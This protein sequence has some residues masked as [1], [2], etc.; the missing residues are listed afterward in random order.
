MP[1]VEPEV[2]VLDGEHNI[3][4]S[5]RVSQEVISACY[6]ELVRQ[7][8]LLEGTLLKPN[9]VLAGRKCAE[10]PDAATVARYTLRVL[11]NTV[12]PAVPGIVFLSGGMS[13]EEATVNLNSLNRVQGAKPWALSFSFGRA[14]QASALKAWKGEDA[15]IAAMQATLL[16][17]AQV[18][19][20]THMRAQLHAD[21]A[22]ADA[23]MH[24]CGG[25]PVMT[26]KATV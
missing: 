9:M 10:Q 25:G 16:V 14:L 23:Q 8:V 11:Q 21:A 26:L 13:E 12:P 15:N 2:L 4:Q 7:N 22:R 6:R 18:R 24:V 1:I 5:A 20:R 3:D 19:E 17:R